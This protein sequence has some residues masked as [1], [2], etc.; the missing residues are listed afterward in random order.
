MKLF[1]YTVYDSKAECYLSPFYCKSKGE[2]L[3]SF[4]EIANDKQSQIGKYPEDFTMFELGEFD[5]SNAEFKMHKA[6]IALGCAIE[7]VNV[8]QVNSKISSEI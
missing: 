2:A 3:R 1:I 5:D 4:A 6:S 7:F 8:A